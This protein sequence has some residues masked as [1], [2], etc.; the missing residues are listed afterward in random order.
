MHST[1]HNANVRNYVLDRAI[2]NYELVLF[3]EYI[4]YVLETWL[5]ENPKKFQKPL[6]DLRTMID[7]LRMKGIIHVDAHFRNVLT[8][9]EQTYLTDTLNSL[10]LNAVNAILDPMIASLYAQF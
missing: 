5:R 9:G 2:A 1:A 6:D 10:H 7:F 4:P 3:L 8:D